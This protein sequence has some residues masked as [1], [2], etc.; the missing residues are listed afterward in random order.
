MR[1]LTPYLMGD[2]GTSYRRSPTL[3]EANRASCTKYDSS[4]MTY[5]RSKEAYSK[6]EKQ[7]RRMHPRSKV[8]N[9]SQGE[10][11][12]VAS[13][14]AATSAL[15]TMRSYGLGAVCRPFGDGSFQV[16]RTA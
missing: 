10:W 12:R 4:S 2:P 15:K 11:V 14:G 8:L 16:V 3:A 5:Q 7:R 13:K 6:D 1:D 9:L